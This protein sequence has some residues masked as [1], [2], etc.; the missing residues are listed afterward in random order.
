MVTKEMLKHREPTVYSHFPHTHRN[1]QNKRDQ[2]DRQ[3]NQLKEWWEFFSA[4]DLKNGN[5]DFSCAKRKKQKLERC[6]MGKRPLHFIGLAA[7]RFRDSYVTS[8]FYLYPDNATSHHKS[9]RIIIK[10]RV[11]HYFTIHLSVFIILADGN[12]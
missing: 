4:E 1:K 8:L 3:K 6:E 9:N 7:A 11:N 10:L 2:G 12:T 5:S